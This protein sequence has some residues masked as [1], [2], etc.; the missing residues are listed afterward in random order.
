MTNASKNRVTVF[1]VYNC[2]SDG[3][4]DDFHV[5][6]FSSE[7]DALTECA[8]FMKDLLNDGFIFTVTVME[9]MSPRITE[10]LAREDIRKAMDIFNDSQGDI[11]VRVE[12]LDI[13]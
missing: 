11:R 6:P 13:K 2:D 12:T 1:Q 9:Y 5:Y 4:P 3:S 10:A 8:G 7:E